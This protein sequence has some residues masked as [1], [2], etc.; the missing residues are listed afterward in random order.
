[1]IFLL[2]TV[3]LDLLNILND[4]N[5][6]L[7]KN[8]ILRVYADDTNMQRLS[9]ITYWRCKVEMFMGLFYSNIFQII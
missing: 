1:M 2:L 8:Y 9:K 5:G 6:C 4:N 3:V 7:V